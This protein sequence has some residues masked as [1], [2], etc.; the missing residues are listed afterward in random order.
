M[1][2][3]QKSLN[4]LVKWQPGQSGNPNAKRTYAN[5]VKAVRAVSNDCLNR[6]QEILFDGSVEDLEILSKSEDVTPIEALFIAVVMK[7]VQKGDAISLSILMDRFLGKVKD[8]TEVTVR[9]EGAAARVAS[10]SREE[11][12]KRR[13]LIKNAVK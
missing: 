8:K 10:M 2:Y 5:R 9:A 11:L 12:E 3:N 1:A 6:V 7:A 13:E 4:N